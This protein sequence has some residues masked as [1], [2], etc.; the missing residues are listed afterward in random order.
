MCQDLTPGVFE[1][2][3]MNQHKNQLVIYGFPGSGKKGRKDR[4]IDFGNS[5][6]FAHSF[7]RKLFLFSWVKSH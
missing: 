2:E 5:F 1:E 4:E 3:R 7:I 6:L